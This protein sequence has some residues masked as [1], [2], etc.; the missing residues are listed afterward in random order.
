MRRALALALLAGAPA[1][2]QDVEPPAQDVQPPAQGVQPPAQDIG[3]PTQDTEPLARSTIGLEGTVEFV[4]PRADLEVLP[5]DDRATVLAR[6]ARATPAL[7]GTRYELLFVAVRA[8][9]HDLS[10]LV[11]PPDGARPEGLPPLRVEVVSLLPDDHAGDLEALEREA[12][13]VAGRFRLIAIALGVLWA[14]PL[15]FALVRRARRPRPEAPAPPPPPPTL[16][17]QL[18]PLV[19]RAVDGEATREERARLERLLLSYWTERL[20]LS[21]L[22]PGD[23]LARLRR[24]EEAGELLRTVE[25]WLHARDGAASAGD[26]AVLLR[27]YAE[28]RAIDEPAAA[29]EVAR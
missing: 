18:R 16:A 23:A 25:R 7:D 22:P 11:V 12:P 24:H 10:E 2:A 21:G 27:P 29:E 6:V 17:D 1:I 5:L 8:G 3:P 4:H 26:V 15:A 14:V 28:A 19:Q 13:R 9:V 20:D